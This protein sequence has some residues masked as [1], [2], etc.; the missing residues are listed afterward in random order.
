MRRAYISVSFAKRK[1]LEDELITIKS[2]LQHYD[3]DSLIFVDKYKFSLA[4]ETE[5]MTQAIAVIDACDF[6]IAEVSHKGI[7]IGV[8]VGYAKAKGKIIIYLRNSKAEHSTTVAGVSDYQIIY[9]DNNDLQDKFSR[10]LKEISN[11]EC[12]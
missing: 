7:G 10:C 6:L 1:E 8:E 4:E 11:T 9:D 2:T 5:M 3:V 12:R